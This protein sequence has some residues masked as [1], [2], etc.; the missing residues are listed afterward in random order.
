[1]PMYAS[2]VNSQSVSIL[3]VLIHAAFPEA[4]SLFHKWNKCVVIVS[5]FV[6]GRKCDCIWGGGGG[7]VL[8][9]G[10]MAWSPESRQMSCWEEPMGPT[11]SERANGRLELL[12][13]LWGMS[14]YI[15]NLEY[16]KSTQTHT[17][18]KTPRIYTHIQY[19]RPVTIGH[20]H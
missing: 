14:S 17:F 18:I 20:A 6:C 5:V 10:S 11:S 15:H 16:T 1:M 13:L 8:G 9:V 12:H 3:S 7:G 4:K 2:H 19:I